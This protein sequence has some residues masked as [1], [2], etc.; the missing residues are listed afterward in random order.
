MGGPQ[1]VG[2]A[3]E[4]NTDATVSALL[5]LLR[6]LLVLLRR[7]GAARCSAAVSCCCGGELSRI[8]KLRRQQK[9]Q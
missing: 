9:L 6:L 2:G 7:Q 1:A 3:K 5:L 4:A 8:Q